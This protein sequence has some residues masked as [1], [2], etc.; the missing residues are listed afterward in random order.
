M[1]ITWKQWI[2][3][4]D[5]ATGS[6]PA[7]EWP[8]AASAR[9]LEGMLGA[10]WVGADFEP[11]PA[12]KQAASAFYIQ[13]LSRITTRRLHYLDGDERSALT[14]VYQLFGFARDICAKHEPDC[15]R[16]TKLVWTLLNEVVRPLTAK[17]HKIFEDQDGKLTEDQRHQFREELIPR[18]DQLAYYLQLFE[19]LSQS[20]AIKAPPAPVPPTPGPTP[21]APGPAQ[22][23]PFSRILFS[24]SVDDATAD[25]IHLAER[26]EINRRR[27]QAGTSADP[28]DIAG[29]ALSGGGLRSATFAL[30]ALQGLAKNRVLT[31]FDYLSTVS[32]GGYAGSFLSCFLNSDVTTNPPVG[33]NPNELPFARFDAQESAP[34]RHLRQQ[35]I[36]AHRRLLEKTADPGARAGRLAGESVCR[37]AADHRLHA[38]DLSHEFRCDPARDS[39]HSTSTDRCRARNPNR[40]GSQDL[41]EWVLAISARWLSGTWRSDRTG[42]VAMAPAISAKTGLD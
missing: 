42:R 5:P 29:I 30:G 11:T 18:Q 32:G 7:A 9:M 27:G 26:D 22:D 40:P 6:Q 19:A 20:D 14:S 36:I 1:T 34:M 16:F 41:R 12:D 25:A 8:F 17:Y 10:D 2:G 24:P 28:V 35:Q 3:G 31:N 37:A 33:L 4:V 21:P 13:L 15:R 39:I 23:L 38:A